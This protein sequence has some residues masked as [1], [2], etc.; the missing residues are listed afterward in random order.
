MGLPAKKNNQGF[1]TD[2]EIDRKEMGKADTLR[3]N[4]V[5]FVVEEN[6][7]KA[8]QELQDFGNQKSEFPKFRERIARHIS[9]GVDLINAIRAKRNF[10]GVKN[11]TMAK[12]QELN[13]RFRDHFNEL[14]HVL[15]TIEKIQ[16]EL[17]LDDIRSTVWVVKA[18][19]NAVFA[20][21]AIAFIIEAS[22]GLLFNFW[23]VAEDYMIKFTDWIFK[24]IGL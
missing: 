11:L 3:Y 20:I 7:D 18:L 22:R 15:K 17:K 24:A 2:I 9:H 10:P 12:Q 5:T 19:T 6:Y 4:I 16:V 1:N 21:A 23:V 8:I 13:E 14:Q